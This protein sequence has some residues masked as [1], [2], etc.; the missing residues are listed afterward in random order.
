MKNS[1]VHDKLTSVFR[2]TLFQPTLELQ[3]GL[4]AADVDG[5]DSLSHINL[6]V[7]I[8]KEFRIKIT[9]REVRSMKNVGDLIRVIEGKGAVSQASPSR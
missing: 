9:T 6:I 8:E 2:K 1:L 7:A 4:T 5:W 3:E